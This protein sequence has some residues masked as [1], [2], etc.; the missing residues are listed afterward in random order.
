MKKALFVMAAALIMGTAFISC[1]KEN[2][3]DTKNGVFRATIEN[4]D[5]HYVDG[6]H[7]EWEYYNG[8]TGDYIHILDP[9]LNWAGAL[10]L[11]PEGVTASHG[12][13]AV[14]DIFHY[15]SSVDPDFNLSA[16]FYTALCG[17]A[18]WNVDE[19][20]NQV[21]ILENELPVNGPHLP[22]PSIC[23]TT[24]SDL[25]FKNVFG[26]L[27][28]N[29]NSSGNDNIYRVEI[30]AD[31]VL[32]GYFGYYFDADNNPIIVPKSYEYNQVHSFIGSKSLNMRKIA[33]A[34]GYEVYLPICP[35]TY[36]TFTINFYLDE[37][38]VT[39]SL[40]ASSITFEAN[41]MHTLNVTL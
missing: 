14:F 28:I 39:K 4:P 33:P 24:N 37:R 23:R 20:G 31:K 32:S 40:S 7:V 3:N 9:D 26:V 19:D 10:A 17:I 29:V 21:L 2:T 35:Q 5:K 6:T 11:A 34:D 41:K 12:S 18:P 16:P 22:S 25:H 30:V 36:T 38:V 13:V 15:T 27:K 1:E 8:N